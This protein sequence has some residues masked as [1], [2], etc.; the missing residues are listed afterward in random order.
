LHLLRDGKPAPDITPFLGVAAHA[1]FIDAADLSYVH[2][3]AALAE[4]PAVVGTG[5]PMQ[6]DMTGMKDMPGMG[7]ASGMEGMGPPLAPESHVTPDLALHVRAPTSG[8]YVLW[9]QFDGGKKVR[10]VRFV[11]RVS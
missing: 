2:V 7:S 8:T 6:H 1:V 3:H 10:T 5:A 9:I 4:A 11:V